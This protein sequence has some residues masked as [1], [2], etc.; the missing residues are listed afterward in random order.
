[1]TS[2]TDAADAAPAEA[3][4]AETAPA[5]V[6]G[7]REYQILCLFALGVVFLV[8]LQQGNTLL[9]TMLLLIGLLGVL[10]R[11]RIAPIVF[12]LAFAVMQWVKQRGWARFS[13]V[14]FPTRGGFP[15]QDV[16]E[17]MA[18]LAYTLA[19]Y[20]LQGLVLH[21]V[22]PD[23]RRRSGKRRWLIFPPRIVLQRRP[24]TLVTPTEVAW[25]LLGLPLWAVSAQALWALLG[26]PRPLL[27][28]PFW[29]A[30]LVCFGWPLAV[31][32]LITATALDLW[33]RR[34][35]P[36]EL[37]ALYLQDVLWRETRGEQRRLNRWTAWWRIR[38]R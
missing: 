24:G 7:V 4:L 30:R 31:A 14:P 9:S 23:P 12:L 19:H 16:A 6:A 10:T 37:G 20:R 8:D 36:P 34:R 15:A 1:M 3:A 22:P 5:D 27:D 2:D 26:P 33:Q 17:S 21:I 35:S 29:L 25:F 28:L 38:S 18:V 13:G 32:T 11:M